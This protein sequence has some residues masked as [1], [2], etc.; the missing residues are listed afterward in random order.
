MKNGDYILVV[1]PEWYKGKKYRNRYCY[2][3]HLVWEKEHK[4]PVPAGYVIHHKDGNKYNNSPDNL[5]LHSVK[6]HAYLHRPPR[7]MAK[8]KCPTCKKIFIRR[9]R[10]MTNK[11][12]Y[13]CSLH[14]SIKYFAH[15]KPDKIN[16]D[17]DK[18]ENIIEIYSEI[19]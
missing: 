12:L 18:K 2:E 4:C 11:N 16:M 1:A 15:G 14:C 19:V 5:E 7:K 9:K 17:K 10:N 13:F 3:H 6:E 8:C